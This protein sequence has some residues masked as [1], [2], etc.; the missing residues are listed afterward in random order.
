M[1]QYRLNIQV[2]AIEGDEILAPSSLKTSPGPAA[3]ASALG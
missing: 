1:S 2:L 3:L